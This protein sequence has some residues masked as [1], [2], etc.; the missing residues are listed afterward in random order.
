MSAKGDR[1]TDST[2]RSAG[3]AVTHAHRRPSLPR[4]QV[5]AP[6]EGPP[7]RRWRFTS[8]VDAARHLMT[9]GDRLAEDSG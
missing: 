8:A 5:A 9:G 7:G 6:S 2:T 4:P 3:A 1:D